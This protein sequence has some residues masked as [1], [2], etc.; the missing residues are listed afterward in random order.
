MVYIS[1]TDS[2]IELASKVI[3]VKK[4]KATP[5]NSGMKIAV[6][7]LPSRKAI[8]LPHIRSDRCTGSS[9]QTGRSVSQNQVRQSEQH[10]QFRRLLSQTS[11]ACFSVSK[12]PFDDSK[13]ML[14]LGSHR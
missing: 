12:L 4:V 14:Y 10:I 8:R 11:V 9:R 6:S 1:H 2:L 3:M 5:H 7:Q 13:Y